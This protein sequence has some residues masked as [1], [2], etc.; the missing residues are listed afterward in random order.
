MDGIDVFHFS[1]A[2]LLTTI[3]FLIKKMQ[4]RGASEEAVQDAT[5]QWG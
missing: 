4:L 2:T 3:F 5:G 1:R